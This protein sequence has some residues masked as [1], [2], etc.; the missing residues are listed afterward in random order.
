MPNAFH[1]LSNHGK[2]YVTP[3]R[4]GC[5]VIDVLVFLIGLQWGEIALAYVN[6]LNP[7]MIRVTE[8]SEADDWVNRRVAVWVSKNGIITSIS[9][10]VVVGLPDG[11]NNGQELSQILLKT[12]H[13]W[14]EKNL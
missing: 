9:Q 13:A 5:A 14:R 8:E 1:Y 4:S 12:H 10:E 7:S 2:D 11:V 6:A 3:E